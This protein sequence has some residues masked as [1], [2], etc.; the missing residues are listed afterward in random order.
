MC[1]QEINKITAINILETY[2]H[3]YHSTSLNKNYTQSALK[4]TMNFKCNFYEL[5][6]F[7]NKI[8]SKFI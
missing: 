4:Y 8:V 3:I 6:A 5:Y 7:K 2:K 1:E